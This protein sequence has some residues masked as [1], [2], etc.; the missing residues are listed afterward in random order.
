M[1]STTIAT[2]PTPKW[3]HIG[4]VSGCQSNLEVGDPLSGTNAPAVLI[5][6]LLTWVCYIG[7]RQ[8]TRINNAMVLIKTAIIVLFV[9]FLAVVTLA[10]GYAL[11]AHAIRS[12]RR[13][14]LADSPDEPHRQWLC[15]FVAI[16]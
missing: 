5:V 14:D 1:G 4:Q 7:V 6:A 8:S 2:N 10:P 13:L 3:G 9:S 16:H 11:A 12:F 15:L